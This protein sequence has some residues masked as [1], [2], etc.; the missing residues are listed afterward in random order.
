MGYIGAFNLEIQGMGIGS[1]SQM[2]SKQYELWILIELNQ[3]LAGK[4]D[5]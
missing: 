5:T 1:K 3:S 4:L 2:Y